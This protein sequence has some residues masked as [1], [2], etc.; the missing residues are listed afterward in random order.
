MLAVVRA[1]R[2]QT[3]KIPGDTIDVEV[4][5]DNA[6]R[7]LEVPAV[8]EKRLKQEGFLPFFAALSFTHRKEYCCSISDAKKEETRFNRLENAVELL[9]KSE[10]TP[11]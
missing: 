5:R 3:G 1:I 10:R 4:W 2:E 9:R 7:A 6:A 8:L 11:L